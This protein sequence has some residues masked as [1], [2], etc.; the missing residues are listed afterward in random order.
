MP[1]WTK[2][3]ASIVTSSVWC[4]D[5]STRIVWVAMLAMCDQHGI[6]EGSVPGFASL[7]RVTIPQMERALEV[8]SGPDQHSRSKDHDGRRIEEIPGGW[9][10]L[11]YEAY[12]DKPQEKS[13]SYAPY[14]RAYRE[15][16]RLNA[17]SHGSTREPE[18]RREKRDNGNGKQKTDSCPA[19]RD[20]VAFYNGLTGRSLSAQSQA[21]FI[22]PRLAEGVP[23]T[24]L[25]LALLGACLEVF[26]L[27]F[28]DRKKAFLDPETV[29]RPGR[30]DG[31]AEFARSA[32]WRLA[33]ADKV[34]GYWSER[35]NQ[36]KREVMGRFFRA[37]D[38]LLAA[39]GR[40]PL[41]PVAA[42]G[43]GTEAW[44]DAAA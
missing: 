38:E 43:S 23:A 33:D 36:S 37:R 4:Q 32:T 19:A 27:G 7:A 1:G 17:L 18:E 13:G 29:L 31:H 28:N 40:K 3:F 21:K 8:L 39:E 20:V 26:H 16:K 12:R 30:L 25:K 2:L 24:T 22:S 10:L 9:R 42:F 11:N 34:W 14:Q 44:P 6:V 5:D 35:L 41:G 15:R